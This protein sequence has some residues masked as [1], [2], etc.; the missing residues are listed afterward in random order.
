MANKRLWLGMLVLALAFGMTVVGCEED[1]KDELDGTTWEYIGPADGGN[2]TATY[3][4][5]FNS[6]NFTL[7]ISAQ[8]QSVTNSGTYSVSGNTVTLTVTNEDGETGTGTG[9]ISGNK[10]TF[11]GM[12]FTKK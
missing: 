6:P 10:L 4:L 11:S 1:P 9:T 3:V 12:E 7:T 8:G 2:V 5:K